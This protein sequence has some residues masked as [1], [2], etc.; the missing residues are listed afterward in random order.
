LDCYLRGNW[1]VRFV[2][3]S[4]ATNTL[5]IISQV[6]FFTAIQVAGQSSP[7]LLLNPSFEDTPEHSKPPR[8]WYF[9]GQPGE[10]PPDV[11]PNPYFDV[12]QQA[13][14]GNTFVGLVVRDNYTWEALG[15]KL[16]EPLIAGQCYQ[17]SLQACRTN[18]YRSVSRKTGQ[19]AGYTD[20][21]RIRIWGADSN[22][23][24]IELLTAS[25]PVVDTF[26]TTFTF[27]FQPNSDYPFFI[28][29]A[30]YPSDSA[31][32]YRGNVLLDD[33]SPLLPID[34][35]SEEIQA[36]PLNPSFF[37]PKTPE[38]MKALI[39]KNTPGIN[40]GYGTVELTNQYY[41][42]DNGTIF[43]D[44]LALHQLV[45]ALGTSELC[46][47]VI[48]VDGPGNYLRDQRIEMLK[49]KLYYMGLPLHLFR[50]QPF[51]KRDRKQQ[52]TGRNQAGDLMIR[53]R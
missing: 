18:Y 52:W 24:H 41:K 10:S 13:A 47:I 12:Y 14:H 40:F 9:C 53:I 11:H 36:H 51:R 30:F 34:C 38:E 4:M 39:R 6:L 3:R 37:T 21:I 43:Q 23:N 35:R 27:R 19:S 29:E 31:Q 25:E 48:A 1:K 46:S 2:I 20:P 33:C 28:L 45:F 22:C 26:W 8:G 16:Q 5:I 50:V 32:I 49:N 17:F 42:D 44:N 7:I 15:Q